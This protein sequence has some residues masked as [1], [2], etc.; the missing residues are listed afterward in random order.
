[1]ECSCDVMRELSAVERDPARGCSSVSTFKIAAGAVQLETNTSLYI[2]ISV[3]IIRLAIPC[4][5][6]PTTPIYHRTQIKIA[7]AAPRSPTAPCSAVCVPTDSATTSPF[8]S[9]CPPF[10]R[11]RS[12]PFL[13][14]VGR[15]YPLYPYPSDSHQT[16]SPCQTAPLPAQQ[17]GS[18]ALSASQYD[19]YFDAAWCVTP[20][21]IDLQLETWQLETAVHVVEEEEEKEKEEE[22]PRE[23]WFQRLIR[24][25]LRRGD[26]ETRRRNDRISESRISKKRFSD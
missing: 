10:V 25:I 21:S 17:D 26:A 23:N 14:P 22:A 5:S 19:V 18:A 2:Y 20:S 3:F 8:N 13:P 12:Q 15:G 24:G 4:L 1:M 16:P 9:C 11:A 6:L 7:M